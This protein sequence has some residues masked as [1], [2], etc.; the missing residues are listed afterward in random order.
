[1]VQIL[2]AS[3]SHGY[4]ERLLDLLKQER[5]DAL[6][7]CG[8]GEGLEDVLLSAAGCP[9]VTSMVKGNNDFGSCLRNEVVISFGGHRFFM[10]HGHRYRLYAGT[11]LLTEAARENNCDIC[12]FG[13]THRPYAALKDGIWLINPGS[14]SEPRQEGR[15]PTCAVLTIDNSGSAE[16]RFLDARTGQEIK[17]EIR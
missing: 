2:I 4:Q 8:D 5:F 6:F 7:F 1:M 10:T 16:I 14:V 3:D 11:G 15:I 9:A 12:L 17:G 13:H